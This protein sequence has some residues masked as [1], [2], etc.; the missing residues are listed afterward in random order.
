MV[1]LGNKILETMLLLLLDHLGTMLL[2]CLQPAGCPM[3][4]LNG[5]KVVG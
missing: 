4:L 2:L 3:H 5:R 1:I